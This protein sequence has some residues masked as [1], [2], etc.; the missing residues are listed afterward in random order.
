MATPTQKI[1]SDA[2]VAMPT[3][4]V[5]PGNLDMEFA[6]VRA[7]VNGA[8]ATGAFIVVLELLSQDGRI[9]G[10][11]R[12]DQVF[13]AGDT[14]ALTWAPFLRRRPVTSAVS[15]VGASV[16]RSQAT[17]QSAPSS[18]NYDTTISWTTEVFDTAN[19]FDPGTPTRLTANADG[20][21]LVNASAGFVV[22]ATGDRA[23]SIFKNGVTQIQQVETPAPANYFWAGSMSAVTN[24]TAGDFLDLR[25]AQESGGNL[26]TGDCLMSAIVFASG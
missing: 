3:S 22:N 16:S 10:Q 21:W 12:I 11:S 8:S 4:Y 19:I 17:P 14:A 13:A 20:I 2:A 7:R 26:N 1:Y 25:V 23:A 9:M 24:M 18:V 15:V 5:A 6:S